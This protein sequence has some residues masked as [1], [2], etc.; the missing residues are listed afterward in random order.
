MV[1]LGG[2]GLGPGVL[3]GFLGGSKETQ[4]EWISCFFFAKKIVTDPVLLGF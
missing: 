1:V 3:V 4:Q 2:W